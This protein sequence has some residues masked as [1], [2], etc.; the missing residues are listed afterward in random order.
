MG[1]S[2]KTLIAA[3]FA[4]HV[5]IDE[6]FV[7][8]DGQGF[9]DSEKATDHARYLK[10]KEVQKYTRDSIEEIEDELTEQ[11]VESI[12]T[13]TEEAANKREALLVEYEE[14]YGKPAAHNIGTDT[15]EE[16][17]AAKKEA[18]NKKA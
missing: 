6:L 7:T 18:K 3:M 5:K 14:L 4:A 15:L 17:I 1:K 11:E 12:P 8:S 9:T 13:G 10:D 2:I 16:R